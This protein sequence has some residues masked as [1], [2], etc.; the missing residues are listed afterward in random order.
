MARPKRGDKR[1]NLG[2]TSEGM[3]KLEELRYLMSKQEGKYTFTLQMVGAWAVHYFLGLGSEKAM[4]KALTAGKQREEAVL[5]GE[6]PGG[7]PGSNHN[8]SHRAVPVGAGGA[9]HVLV[10]RDVPGTKRRGAKLAEG[11]ETVATP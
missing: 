9:E 1:L 6:K 5:R 2:M 7:N 3:A 4:L 11:N 8:G 10:P